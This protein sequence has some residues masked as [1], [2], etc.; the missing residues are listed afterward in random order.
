MIDKSHTLN[1]P[2]ESKSKLSAV[3]K[4]ENLQR[5]IILCIMQE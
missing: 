5:E 1:R 3:G 2:E 4:Q